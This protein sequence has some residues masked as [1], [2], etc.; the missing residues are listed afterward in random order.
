MNSEFETTFLDLLY[1]HYDKHISY[2]ININVEPHF[3]SFNGF[4]NRT[5]PEYPSNYIIK[6][7][8]L[9]KPK[10]YNNPFSPCDYMFEVTRH[11]NCYDGK[12]IYEK[13]T[14][15]SYT[16]EDVNKIPLLKYFDFESD[17]VTYCFKEID[18]IFDKLSG[19]LSDAR[20]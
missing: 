6:V 15:N 3:P 12:Y 8:L 20:N 16:I 9:F 10:D 5:E 11:L 19:K 2:V 17:F 13:Y 7:P 4:K 1:E 14:D 18:V